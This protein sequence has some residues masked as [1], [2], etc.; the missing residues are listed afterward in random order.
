MRMGNKA[1]CH[2]F[3]DHSIGRGIISSSQ[4]TI[5]VIQIRNSSDGST[6]DT[7]G[8]DLIHL[9]AIIVWP[10]SCGHSSPVLLVL[11]CMIVLLNTNHITSCESPDPLIFK[12]SIMS[13]SHV[14][15]RHA[16]TVTRPRVS[17]TDPR[18]ST[19]H[20]QCSAQMNNQT[21]ARD[22]SSKFDE[23]AQGVPVVLAAGH[24]L[25][26]VVDQVAVCHLRI[27]VNDV[28]QVILRVVMESKQQ[29]HG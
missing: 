4:A 16:T 17:I 10:S 2:K 26:D 20:S 21:I 23:G 11:A 8:F 7:G 29:P 1:S 6:N 14:R 25:D 24:V 12:G 5:S 18:I 19:D 15:C 3:E 27:L 22:E 28:A 9:K 13:C